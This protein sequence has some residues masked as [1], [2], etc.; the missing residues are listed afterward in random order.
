MRMEGRLAT[1]A[2]LALLT[3]VALPARA[4]FQPVVMKVKGVQQQAELAGMTWPGS[5]DHDLV[6]LLAGGTPVNRRLAHHDLINLLY[7][8]WTAPGTSIQSAAVAWFDGGPQTSI[9]DVAW[10]PP[11]SYNLEVTWGESPGAWTHFAAIFTRWAQGIAAIRLLPRAQPVLLATGGTRTVGIPSG[12]SHDLVAVDLS[13]GAGVMTPPQRTWSVPDY[14]R[15]VNGDVS[16][17]RIFPLRLSPGARAAGVED[18]IIPFAKGFVML[19]HDS[20]PA[21]GVPLASLAI[22]PIDFGSATGDLTPF[23]PGA[24][25][26]TLPWGSC[27]GAAGMDVDGDGVPDLV[28]AFGEYGKPSIGALLW[29][30]NGG[31][32]L[33]MKAQQPW[34]QLSGRADLATI[35]SVGTLRQLELDG[36]ET[37]FVVADPLAEKLVVVRGDGASGFTTTEL[38]LAGAELSNAIAVDVVGS[39]ARDLVALVDIAPFFSTS[40]VWIYPDVGDL[41]PKLEWAP[42]PPDAWPIGQDLTLS[43]D[44]S[45]ADAPPLAL[46]WI[47]PPASDVLDATSVTIDGA[48]LCD[49]ATPVDVTVR[50]M[51]ALG[52]YVTLQKTIAMEARPSL[53]IVGAAPPGRIVLLPGGTAARAEGEAWPR[54]AVGVPSYTWGQVGLAGLVET[55][56]QTDGSAAAWR[57]FTLPEAAYPEALAG[58]PALTLTAAGATILSPSVEGTATLPLELDGTGLVSAEVAFDEPALAP[59]ELGHVRVR[60]ESRLG[61]ALPAVLAR[62]RLAGLVFAGPPTAEGSAASP[63]AE[64][65]ELVIDLLPAAGAEVEIVAPVRSAGGTG[66]A[67][68][69]L[70][71]SSGVRLSPAA[72]PAT[73]GAALPG[74]GCASGR[75]GEGL[76]IALALLVLGYMKPIRRVLARTR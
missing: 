61:V 15:A 6:V 21:A 25:A 45:D 19:W 47:R 27:L 23:L 40:E 44:A 58:A 26:T 30:S 48:T 12:I 22:T 64:E 11:S 76:P 24:L 38:P 74:C 52:V 28:F 51:D 36:G 49:P 43:V 34:G 46:R 55:A 67:S 50:A 68:V 53:S 72:A 66:G 31:Q 41:A 59:G 9:P 54:C 17:D 5:T 14:G 13:G 1:V 3:S 70:F 35:T 2:V 33:A 57:E 73:A 65:G 7:A 60:I 4:Q 32:P 39:P 71:S 18:A 8:P 42:V 10:S 20:V 56:R 63:G 37:A 16:H 29:I 75:G 62:L 69:E